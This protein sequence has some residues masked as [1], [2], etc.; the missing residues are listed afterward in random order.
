MII[1]QKHDALAR[2]ILRS[3]KD[4]GRA[5][6]IPLSMYRCPVFFEDDRSNAHDCV[7]FFNEVN[8]TPHPGGE[9]IIVPI[10][11]LVPELVVEKLLPTAILTLWEGKDIGKAEILAVERC[12]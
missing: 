9:A 5:S 2:V 11:F 6:S 1:R 3:T 10:S 4:G 12:Q 7:F 8:V